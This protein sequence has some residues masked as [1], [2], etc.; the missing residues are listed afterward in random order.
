MS[1]KAGGRDW[2]LLESACSEYRSRLFETRFFRA[3]RGALT[4]TAVAA[5]AAAAALAV[6]V[7]AAAVRAAL[8]SAA[9]AV[10]EGSLAAAAAAPVCTAGWD[11]GPAAGDPFALVVVVVVV[12]ATRLQSGDRETGGE[13]DDGNAPSRLRGRLVLVRCRLCGEEEAEEGVTDA[14]EEPGS[15]GAA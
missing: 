6:A 9:V 4:G 15:K 3:T 2:V 13:D 12:F 5:A 8:F 1:R 11:D 14:A 10:T 7:A